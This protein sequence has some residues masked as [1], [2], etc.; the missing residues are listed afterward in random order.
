ML[1][2]YEDRRKQQLQQQVPGILIP[3]VLM[4]LPSNGIRTISSGDAQTTSDHNST[5]HLLNALHLPTPTKGTVM[6][7][8]GISVPGAVGQ[9]RCALLSGL[10]VGRSEN[11]ELDALQ[12]AAVT[13][14]I[15]SDAQIIT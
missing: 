6:K 5:T 9:G 3:M 8:T 14:G 10:E 15:A 7:M 4:P 1:L 11:L 2:L 13:R 12:G